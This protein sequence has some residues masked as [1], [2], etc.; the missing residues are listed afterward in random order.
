MDQIEV[1]L[2]SGHSF[3]ADCTEWTIGRGKLDGDLRELQWTTPDGARRR[4]AYIDLEQVA[5]IV[6]ISGEDKS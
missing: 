3:V 6:S 2:K 5:A 4:L 1:H